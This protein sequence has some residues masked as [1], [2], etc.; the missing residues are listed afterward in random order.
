[1]IHRSLEQELINY[2]SADDSYVIYGGDRNWHRSKG[3]IGAWSNI[4]AIINKKIL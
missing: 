4:D 2:A 1:M 3:N